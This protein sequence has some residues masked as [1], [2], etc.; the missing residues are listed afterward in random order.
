MDENLSDKEQL[1]RIKQWWHEYGWFLLGG[2]GLAVAGLFGWNQYQAYL[3]RRAEA[4][5]MLYV[6]LTQSIEDDRGDEGELLSRLRNEYPGSPYTQ[7]AALRVASELVVR[8]PERAEAELRGVMNESDDEQLATIARLRL[9]RLLAYRERHDEA[10]ALLD[11]PD[12]GQFTAPIA[13]IRGDIQSALGNV[14]AARDA[15]SQALT[16]PGAQNLDRNLL[17]MKLNALQSPAAGTDGAAPGSVE[18]DAAEPASPAGAAPEAAEPEAEPGA[19][20]PEEAEPG[21]AEPGAAAPAEPETTGEG[22]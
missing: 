10:L 14:A 18:P 17:Q 9:A 21:A 5:S 8:E 4:A 22:A 11:V 15:F 20:A 16:A 19:V 1:E 3:D 2:A 7:Q 6:E 12:P 13:S